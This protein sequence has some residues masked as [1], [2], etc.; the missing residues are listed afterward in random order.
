MVKKPALD[1]V[2][3]CALVFEKFKNLKNFGSNLRWVHILMGICLWCMR[4]GG[5]SSPRHRRPQP[6]TWWSASCLTNYE[7][8]WLLQEKC[9]F[10]KCGHTFRNFLTTNCFT[11]TSNATSRKD[12]NKRSGD[13]RQTRFAYHFTSLSYLIFF[14]SQFL[15][16]CKLLI[17]SHSLN[18]GA[19]ALPCCYCQTASFASYS[20]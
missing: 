19:G 7:F 6:H 1:V 3:F 15:L 14:V 2:E 13:F 8:K 17:F 12:I 11:A 4:L 9:C 20:L 18:Q 10:Q 5:R 16:T